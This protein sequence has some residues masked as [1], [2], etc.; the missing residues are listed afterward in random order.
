[1]NKNNTSQWSQAQNKLDPADEDVDLASDAGTDELDVLV[2]SN[3]D[4]LK[5]RFLDRLAEVFA[6]QKRP[7]NFVSC[8]SMKEDTPNRKVTINV[9][10][11]ASFKNIDCKFRDEL[12]LNLGKLHTG[13]HV[14]SKLDNQY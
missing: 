3:H 5:K 10:R 2:Q 6:M 13:M 4:D 9:T 7:V 11:N 12:A 1:M 14:Q 8:T